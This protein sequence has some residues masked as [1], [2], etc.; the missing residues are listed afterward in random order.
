MKNIVSL[1]LS[2]FCFLIAPSSLLAQQLSAT[3]ISER[4][5]CYFIVGSAGGFT[6]QSLRYYFFKDGSVYKQINTASELDR[7]RTISKKEVKKLFRELKSLQLKKTSFNHPGNIT[8][9]IEQHF[10]SEVASV[11]W[12]DSSVPVPA[13]LKNFY[14]AAM[15]FATP[16]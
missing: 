6:G 11:A 13:S 15:D 9:S 12:G 7:V 2:L 16:L 3:S 5:S 10:K 8:Y 4:N 14:R 1:I